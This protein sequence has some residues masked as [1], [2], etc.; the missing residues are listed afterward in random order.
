MASGD[1]AVYIKTGGER[2][3]PQWWGLYHGYI[4][5]NQDPLDQGRVKLRIPQVFGNT[6]SGWAAPMVP[7]NYI[8]PVGTPVTAMFVGG[9]PTQPVWFGNF[10]LPGTNIAV[11]STPPANPV[12]GQIWI[13]S[14]SNNEMEEWNGAGWVAYEIGGVNIADGA[15]TNS[16]IA[17]GTVVAGIIDGTTVTG[18]TLENSTSDPKTSVNPDGSITITNS[19]G[20]V[21]YK[22]APDGTTTW[23]SSTGAVLMQQSPT[24]VLSIQ[25]PAVLQ[26]PSGQSWEES[27]SANVQV[28]VGGTSPAQF[29]Q[30]AFIGPATNAVGARDR[31]WLTF[32][33]AAENNT[34]SANLELTYEGSNGTN[35]EYAYMD[36]T[37]L[38]ILAGSIVAVDPGSSPATPATWHTI[39]LQNGYSAGTNNGFTDVPQVRMMA[40]NKTLMFKG[41]LTVPAS[42]SS[43]VWGTLPT[44]FPNANM[45]GPYGV[46]I[47]ANYSGGVSDHI[48]VQNNANLSLNNYSAHGGDTFN[49]TCVVPT[50]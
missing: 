9:D 19:S 26:F 3:V 5:V 18:S 48:Q 31:V 21:I 44:G 41:S 46:G 25:D 36:I 15:I 7:V 2:K 49:I 14:S 28:A 20:A 17:V 40:D 11:S 32:N 16:K 1:G 33:S 23:Y 10:A 37:G 24:G 35:H 6:T 42:P 27:P 30:M 4:A 13:N 8:P 45:G 22:V 43:A 34:S 29:I 47:V 50:Q 38:N 39:A 12:V